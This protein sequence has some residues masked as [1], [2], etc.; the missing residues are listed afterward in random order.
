LEVYP[1]PCTPA[2]L[3][4]RHDQAVTAFAF[5]LV[6]TAA[7]LHVT[8]N[9]IIKSAGDPLRASTVAMVTAGVVLVPI[10]AAAWAVTGRPSIPPEALALGL[11]SGAAEA[12]YFALLSAAY[13]RGDLSVV[14]PIARGTAPLLAVAAGVL[15]LGEQ[16]GPGGVLGVLLLLGGLLALQRPWRLLR[17]AG[18]DSFGAAEFAF[19]TGVAIAGYSAIDRVGA[20]A[21]APWLYAA[22]I[23]GTGAIWMLLLYYFAGRGGHSP[24]APTA[25]TVRAAAGG[26]VSLVAYMLILGAYTLAPLSAV[27]PLRE[28]AIVVAAA[29]GS[30]RLGEASGRAAVFRVGAAVVVVAGAVL[31]ALEASG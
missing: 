8:W 3:W 15:L 1:R 18:R 6:L 20:R 26:I 24:P 11:V 14:Y 27:A 2:P 17:R 10:S 12:V 5:A 16:L 28:S 30:L 31:L 23:F 29:W 25:E 22:I 21:T 9:V 7:V 19:L 4:R 13:R